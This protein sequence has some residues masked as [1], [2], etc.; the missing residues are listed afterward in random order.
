MI[1]KNKHRYRHVYLKEVASFVSKFR[2]YCLDNKL[3][4][5]EL[6]KYPKWWKL[7]SIEEDVVNIADEWIVQDIKSVKHWWEWYPWK[8]HS[9]QLINNYRG[10]LYNNTFDWWNYINWR[11]TSN[12]LIYFHKEALRK[13]EWWKYFDWDR[14]SGKTLEM[15]EDATF[16]WWNYYNWS[17]S[18]RSFIATNKTNLLKNIPFPWWEHVNW[19]KDL[20]YTKKYQPNLLEMIPK[21][22][23][24]KENLDD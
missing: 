1:R 19:N 16:D 6:S 18:F 12:S 11:T 24:L 21:D 13:I 2:Y 8:K 20:S 23:R 15:L 14:H 22:Y 5:T 17:R 3:P 9:K 4:A 7:I 10:F